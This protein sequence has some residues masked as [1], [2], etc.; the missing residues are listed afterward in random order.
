[1]NRQK[2]TNGRTD[3]QTDAHMVDK[4][5]DWHRH[6]MDLVGQNDISH[7]EPKIFLDADY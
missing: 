6:I 2:P 7:F 3:S 4:H 5:M 1:M